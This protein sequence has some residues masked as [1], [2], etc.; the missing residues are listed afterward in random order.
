MGTFD[1]FDKDIC[2]CIDSSK[3]KPFLIRRKD[4]T[5][6]LFQEYLTIDEAIKRFKETGK[7]FKCD[8]PTL[9]EAKA[10]KAIYDFLGVEVDNYQ[11]IATLNYGRTE[12]ITYTGKNEKVKEAIKLANMILGLVPNELKDNMDVVGSSKEFLDFCLRHVIEAQSL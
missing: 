6:N 11:V 12:P 7:G 10:M 5:Y 3:T 2:I 1:E 4:R 9:T 8:E